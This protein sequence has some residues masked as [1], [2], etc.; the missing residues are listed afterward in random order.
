[1][2]GTFE[3][4]QPCRAS[5]SRGG[6]HLSLLTP[7]LAE[8]VTARGLRRG[9]SHGGQAGWEAPCQRQWLCPHHGELRLRAAAILPGWAPESPA[10]DPAQ[11]RS[12]PP[13]TFAGI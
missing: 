1:M 11:T 5:Y 4:P 8:T 13:W 6:R 12:S 7:R 9:R 10:S 3:E 2:N